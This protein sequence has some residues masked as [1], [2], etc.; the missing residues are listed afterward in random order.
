LAKKN[1]NESGEAKGLQR[2]TDWKGAFMIGLSAT[3]LVTGI[4]PYAAQSMGAACVQVFLLVTL[5][6]LVLCLCLAE[7]AAMMPERS[8]GLPAYIQE[9][10][11]VFGSRPARH[12]GGFSTWCYTLGWF[13]VAP[14]NMILASNY[15]CTLLG[16]PQ[17]PSFTPMGVSISL[18]VLVLSILGMCLLAIPCIR[19]IHLG[20]GFATFLGIASMLPLTL[21]VFLP[22]AKPEVLHWSNLAGFALAD[23]ANKTWPFYMSWI[24][25]IS[26]S[27]LGLE[28][29]ACYIAE[30][31]NPARDAKIS[32]AAEAGYGLFIYLS[33]P[34]HAHR[35][36]RHF[37]EC[38]S[39]DHLPR[40]HPVGLRRYALGQ[41]VHQ[42][43]SHRGPASFLA[44]RPDGLRPLALPGRP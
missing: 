44:Q 27:V 9:S 7:L 31:K 20:A 18:T 39:P 10:F 2:K 4:G 5:M 24:F 8:G 6:A 43:A 41:V 16:I 35:R 32:L 34:Y 17:G 36:A 14:I 40:L 28:A 21:L 15:I 19:G 25:I 3:I 29:A 38:R 23:P 30:C 11:K 26:W 12:L 42:P 33:V 37:K 22:F 1:L 13:P